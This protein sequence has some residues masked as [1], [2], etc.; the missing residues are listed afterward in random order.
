MVT[1]SGCWYIPS[2]NIEIMIVRPTRY[3][4]TD[5]RTNIM[6]LSFIAER[7]LIAVVIGTTDMICISG[8]Y[9]GLIIKSLHEGDTHRPEQGIM[10]TPLR[11]G[12]RKESIKAPNW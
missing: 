10:A 2:F 8:C 11:I 9:S 6:R 3:E 5:V 7:I 12:G 1:V 4:K